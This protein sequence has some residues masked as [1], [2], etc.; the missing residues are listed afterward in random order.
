ML[1]PVLRFNTSAAAHQYAELAD[2]IG[3][4]GYGNTEERA[5]AFIQAIEILMSESGSPR[6]LRD[7]GVTED[8]LGMLADEAMKQTRLLINNPI[9]LQR[10][11]AMAL[12]REA[13]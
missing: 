5:D 3:V 11:D 1:G 10:N 6:R 9:A 13:Y 4:P 2:V 8:S 12:Y 7:V